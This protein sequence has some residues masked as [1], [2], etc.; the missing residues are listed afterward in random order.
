[1]T[2]LVLAGAVGWAVAALSVV[3]LLRRGRP[4]AT[5]YR[6]RRLPVVLGMA[7]AAA[8][9]TVLA[10][11][12]ATGWVSRGGAAVRATVALGVGLGLVF[13]AGLYDDLRTERAH[14]LLA[15]LRPL[16]RGRLTSGAVKLVAIVAGAVLVAWSQETGPV[17]LLLGAPVVAGAANLWNLLDVVPGR[18]A[19]LFLPAAAPLAV[20]VGRMGFSA[21]AQALAA[22]GGAVVAVFALDLR[23]RAMLGD[24]GA[25]LLGF[26]VGV[27]LLRV[28]S[29]PWLAVALGAVVALHVAGETVTLSRLIR[30]VPPL[31]WWDRLGRLPP[32]SG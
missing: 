5:N 13:A 24:S 32:P 25:N 6:N 29:T 18:A 17:R 16:A 4:W 12:G 7:V 8:V 1:V 19:K 20:A 11:L 9:G 31:R 10:V 26:L 21:E 3:P 28:L 15:Q 27:G 23:E 14:G 30:A 2:A 22:A